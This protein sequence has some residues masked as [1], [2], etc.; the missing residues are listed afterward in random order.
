MHLNSAFSNSTFTFEA[1][2]TNDTGA[3]EEGQEDF[4][5]ADARISGRITSVLGLSSFQARVD[6]GSFGG[7][8]H[9]L[10]QFHV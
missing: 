1:G 3:G 6:G 5:T 7:C 4:L 2:L 9:H 10:W 8:S